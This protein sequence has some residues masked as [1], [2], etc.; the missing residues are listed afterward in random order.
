MPVSYAGSTLSKSVL[1]RLKAGLP[2][3]TYSNPSNN[4]IAVEGGG[5]GSGPIVKLQGTV[6]PCLAPTIQS[7][8][9][10][11]SSVKSSGMTVNLTAGDGIGRVVVVNTAN[12]F[13]NPVSSNVLPT[14]NNIYSGGEQVIYAGVGNSV[15][16]TGLASSTTYYFRVFEYNICSNNYIYNVAAVTNN[17]RSQATVCDIPLNPNGE[18]TPSATPNCGSA[19]LIYEHGTAQPQSGVIYYWQATASGTSLANPV[20]FVNGSVVS[21]PF[22][23]TSSGYYYVRAYNGNCWSTGSYAMQSQVVISTSANISIQPTDQ[24]VVSGGNVSF[25]VTASGTAPYTY[26]WQESATGMAGS[27]TTVG[28]N[29]TYTLINTPISKNGYKYRV[30]ISNACASKTS[31]VVTLTVTQG[32]CLTESFTNIPTASSTSYQTVAGQEIMVGL[33]QRQMQERIRL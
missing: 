5:D 1:V 21:E 8:V 12:S 24:S 29:A 30:I 31:N 27:W 22:E 15:S 2:A 33:G 14:A 9:V 18:I 32:P 6:S 13:T 11:F 25:T 4:I 19:V 23:V 3:G 10:S 26:Q 16:V 28:T 7:S 20:V 17:P